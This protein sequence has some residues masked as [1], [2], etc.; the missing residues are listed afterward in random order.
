MKIFFFHWQ[1]YLE[2]ESKVKA[3][4]QCLACN[5][6]INS[7]G[8]AFEVHCR[9]EDHFK[10]YVQYAKRHNERVAAAGA[11]KRARTGRAGDPEILE[12]KIE[13]P[14]DEEVRFW[15]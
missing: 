7:K 6:K 9:L 12:F 13:D 10:N 8:E 15:N 11:A 1:V 3:V 2:K 4:F 5:K 14:E